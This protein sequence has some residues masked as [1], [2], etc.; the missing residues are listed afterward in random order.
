MTRILTILPLIL[1]FCGCATD[2]TGSAILQ[3]GAAMAG[4]ADFGG[5]PASFTSG[6]NF[7][8]N[9]TRAKLHVGAVYLNRAVSISGAQAT[10]CILQGIYVAEITSPLDV[11]CLSPLPQNFPTLGRGTQDSAATGEIWLSGG[12]VNAEDDATVIVDLAGTASKQGVEYAFEGQ[13]HIG[14]TRQVPPSDPAQPGANPMCKQRIVSPIPINIPLA[15]NG[16][17]LIRVDPRT[18]FSNVDFSQLSVLADKSQLYFFSDAG[19]KQPD[20]N[21]YSAIRS[22]A[23]WQFQWRDHP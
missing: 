7:K 10:S 4:P 1:L 17:L 22:R 9:L 13:L 21:L 20:I 11:D 19:E 6:L 3:F 14:K 5:G 12:D 15:P 16:S 2:S 18:W 23:P 8:V